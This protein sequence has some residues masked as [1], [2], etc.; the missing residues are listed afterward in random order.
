MTA[1]GFEFDGDEAEWLR[2]F[3][4]LKEATATDYEA[5]P[6]AGGDDFLLTNW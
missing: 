3:L 6:G 1:L 4:A 2:W 5:A